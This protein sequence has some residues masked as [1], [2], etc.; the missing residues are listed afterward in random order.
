MPAHLLAG[1]V[2]ELPLRRGKLAGTS[3]V[4]Q[5]LLRVIMGVRFIITKVFQV[6]RACTLTWQVLQCLLDGPPRTI[7]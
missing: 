5:T 4:F 7:L 2:D 1:H 6:P 3:F